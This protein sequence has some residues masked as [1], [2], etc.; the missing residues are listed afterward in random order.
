[1][2]MPLQA[3]IETKLIY[4]QQSESQLLAVLQKERAAQAR[5]RQSHDHK[6]GI[7]AFLEKRRPVFQNV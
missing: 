7:Q 2:N 4:F 3:F 1:M 5:L 6:E